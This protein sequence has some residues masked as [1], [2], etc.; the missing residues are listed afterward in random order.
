MPALYPNIGIP[1]H[2]FKCPSC[3]LTRA[4]ERWMEGYFLR[5]RVTI[6]VKKGILTYLIN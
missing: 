4:Q 3:M 2:P 6:L 1:P 5:P